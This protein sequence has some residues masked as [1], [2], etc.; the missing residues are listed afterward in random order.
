MCEELLLNYALIL[1]LKLLF[2][3]YLDI[4]DSLSFFFECVNISK[5]KEVEKKILKSFKPVVA[6]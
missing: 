2:W 5:S 6:I 3:L 4:N 1:L